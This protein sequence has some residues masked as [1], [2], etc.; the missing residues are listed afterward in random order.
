[1][2]IDATVADLGFFLKAPTSVTGPGG[3]VQL[4]YRDRRTDQEGELAVVIG[5]RARQLPPERALDCV[6]G[7]TCLLDITVRGRED[8]S[9]RKSFDTFTP[10]GPWITTADEVGDPGSLELRCWVNGE[11]RQHAATKDFIVGVADLIAY[12]SSVL[13][14]NPGD[15]IATGTP[16]GV[17][18][19]AHGDKVAV[20]IDRVGRLEVSV[21]AETA[22]AWEDRRLRR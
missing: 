20:E 4:P 6:F 7:Y 12:I 16:A 2:K 13:T 9:M 11:L 18:P 15:I 22:V 19:L 8:R 17:G 1:M 21:S 14:L 5:T 3:M 10:I